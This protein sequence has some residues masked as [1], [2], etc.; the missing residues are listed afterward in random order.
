M[1]IVTGELFTTR[2]SSREVEEIIPRTQKDRALKRRPL[3]Q[4]WPSLEGAN[5]CWVTSQGGN[6]RH[7]C[8]DDI[9]SSP[10]DQLHWLSLAEPRHGVHIDLA[11]EGERRVEKDRE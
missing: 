9:L 7:E 4:K 11:M 10:S 3:A 6:Q 5:Q 1:I 8:P 2:V